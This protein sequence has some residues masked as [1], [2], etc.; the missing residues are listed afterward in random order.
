MKKV[1]ST[2]D[3]TH[4][5]KSPRLS[6]RIFNGLASSKLIRWNY[7][8]RVNIRK[9]REPGN[10]AR[11]FIQVQ[12]LKVIT[13]KNNYFRQTTQTTAV[14]SVKLLEVFNVAVLKMCTTK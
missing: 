13:T 14:C 10:E 12:N 11:Q 6:P 4:V 2:L 3:V 9:G 8:T 5:I 7:C 1:L